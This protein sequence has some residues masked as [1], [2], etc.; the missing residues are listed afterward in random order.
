MPDFVIKT[1]FRG[2]DKLSPILKKL[3]I[4]VKQTGDQASRSFKKASRQARI[5]GGVVKGVLAAGM[6]QRGFSYATM[7]VRELG[8]E[9]IDFDKNITKAVTRLPGGLDRSSQAFKDMGMIARREAMR[10]EFSAAQTAAAIEQLALA[11]F[12]LNQSMA[13]LPGTIDLA[14]NANIAVEE[15]TTIA[16]KTLGAF[17]LKAKDTAQLTT[18]L[19]RVNDVF[20]KTVSSATLDITGL[21]ETLKF[22]GPAAFAAGQSI[23]TFSAMTGVMADASIDASI[24]GTSMRRMFIELTKS[25]KQTKLKKIGV[26]VKD[27]S[28]NFRD[29]FDILKDVA[30]GTEHMGKVQRLAT[31][32]QIFGARAVGAVNVLLNRGDESLRK[33][34]TS[35]EKSGGAAKKMA[36]TIR[37]S[38]GN[39]LLVL[40]SALIELGI[41]FIEAFTGKAGK[42]LDDL[43]KKVQKFNMKPVIQSVKDA[44]KFTKDLWDAIKP[45]RDFL[46]VIIGLWIGWK[47]ILVATVA[48]Q[49]AK[50]FIDLAGAIK[51]SSISLAG[52]KTAFMATTVSAG[53]LAFAIVGLVAALAIVI[54]KNDDVV[55][56]FEEGFISM[57]ISARKFWIGLKQDAAKIINW[58][59]ESFSFLP[60]A[61]GKL[62]GID[63]S[64]LDKLRV[65]FV[66]KADLTGLAEAEQRLKGLREEIHGVGVARGAAGIRGVG[67]GRAPAPVGP[68]SD[69][70]KALE[71]EFELPSEIT[72]YGPAEQAAQVIRERTRARDIAR[73]AVQAVLSETAMH[74]PNRSEAEAQKIMSEVLLRFENAPAGMTAESKTTGG[75]PVRTEGLGTQ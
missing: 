59:I 72:R 1:Q 10:T 75:K 61:F 63:V 41:K 39:R 32:E 26:E 9:F 12:D 13:A 47:A 29:F 53:V 16:A 19:A 46:P 44:A 42:G 23:E 71:K 5:F 33:F 62:L 24:A 67:G 31:L 34:R 15:A 55:A 11:G 17:G 40:R 38:I 66:D 8:T 50:F 18:N 7:A 27:A 74:A 36:D 20:S 21:F 73:E 25:A 57:E 6:I 37:K 14:T 69:I 52:M 3:G 64:E 70:T 48:V 35:L 49:A 56:G 60:K 51:L 54:A 68:V 4:R 2:A 65:D 58:L 45:F 30:K 28:G 22:G 43:I